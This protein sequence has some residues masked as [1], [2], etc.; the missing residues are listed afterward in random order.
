MNAV[1]ARLR[2]ACVLVAVIGMASCKPAHEAASTA[3]AGT[4]PAATDAAPPMQEPPEAAAAVPATGTIEPGHEV[5]TQAC[6]AAVAKQT[7]VEASR[8]TVIEVLWA[9]AGV[10]VTIQVPDAVA[11]WS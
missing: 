6:L 10:G 11:P 7:N 2:A 8:L 5:A 1:H 9:E 4:T 3:P